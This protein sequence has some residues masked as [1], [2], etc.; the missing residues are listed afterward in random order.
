MSEEQQ[1]AA[2]AAQASQPQQQPPQVST[3]IKEW[4]VEQ[5]KG[6]EQGLKAYAKEPSTTKWQNVAS[7]VPGKTPN[8]C[9]QRFSYLREILKQKQASG[10]KTAN[11][12]T[13]TQVSPTVSQ[14]KAATPG[15]NPT[16]TSS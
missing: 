10:P 16:K 7:M 13:A 8:E 5:Q 14:A 2:T 11:T 15:A 12:N 6:L 1:A 3:A 4:T 9:F